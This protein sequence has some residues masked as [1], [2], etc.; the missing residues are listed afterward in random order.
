M[1][2][3][4]KSDAIHV[5][6]ITSMLLKELTSIVSLIKEISGRNTSVITN[7]N[8]IKQSCAQ[9]AVVSTILVKKLLTVLTDNFYTCTSNVCVQETSV[10]TV[11]H[12]IYIVISRSSS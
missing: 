4:I 5:W 12:H 2:V 7:I 8:L 1:F 11:N 10:F 6:A 3:I 9:E